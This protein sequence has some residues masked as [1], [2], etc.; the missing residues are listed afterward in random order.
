MLRLLRTTTFRFTIVYVIVFT[1]AVAALGA[2][3]YNETFGVAAKQTDSVIDQEIEVLAEL[4]AAE[5]A[6]ALRRVIRERAAW[7]DDGLYMLIA[8]PSGAILSGN[9]TALPPEALTAEE[10]F[11]NFVYERPLVDAA[12]REIG[13]DRREARGKIRRFR[14]SPDAENFFLVFVARDIAGRE[15][16]RQRLQGVIVRAALAILAIGMVMGLVFSRSLLRR[17][18]AVNRTAKAIRGGDLSKRIALTG[19]G[20]ELENLA[21]NLNAMLDQIERLMTGMREVSDNIAHDLRSPL[22]RIRNRLTEA[23]KAG[24]AAKNA[25]LRATLEDAERMI[26]TFNALLSIAR[27]ESGEG[28]G[29]MDPVDLAAIAQEVAELYEPAAQEAGFSLSVHTSPCPPVRG[30]RALI[31]QAIA[32]L[33]DNALK[34][35]VD[36]TKI[37]L[38]VGKSKA[39]GVLLSVSDDGPGV[40]EGERPHILKRFVRL[41]TSRSTPGS[42]LGLSL[43]AA[44]ARAHGARL[45]ISD[46]GGQEDRPGLS[47]TLA[48]PAFDRA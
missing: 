32:N 42:G 15:D 47:V 10:D 30:S 39:G 6:G 34:Y 25:A 36:G 3:L 24:D 38:R 20:D 33:L 48:F 37:A 5:G 19:S 16:L 12:G 11:F 9:L 40:P 26:A 18:D 13:V 46:A 23:L 29:H 4:F 35:A 31:S 45:N 44:V 21:I 14:S 17:V 28:A 7:R 2:Y 41:E 1:A 22:T 43:V 27:I 8:A